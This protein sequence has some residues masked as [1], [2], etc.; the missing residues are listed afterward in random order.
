VPLAEPAEDTVALKVTLCPGM[1]GFAED[2]RE[3]VV[4]ACATLTVTLTEAL[5]AL[6]VSPPYDAVR[7]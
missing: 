7:E 3:V 6:F 1:D 5:A 2:V 4:E